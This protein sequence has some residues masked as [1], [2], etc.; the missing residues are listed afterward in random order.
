MASLLAPPTLT[1]RSK[2][3]HV[4][5]SVPCH[6]RHQ[7]VVRS[8]EMS[9][10]AMSVL[11][12]PCSLQLNGHAVFVPTRLHPMTQHLPRTR[13]P[14]SRAQRDLR[15]ACAVLA[16][17]AALIGVISFA[18]SVFKGSSS[19]ATA[20]GPDSQATETPSTTVAPATGAV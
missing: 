10:L 13:R 6:S 8:S 2:T 20:A 17:G 11:A 14:T 1:P 18:E 19:E 9:R 15:R 16:A 5:I 12:G 3:T 7:Q 4:A